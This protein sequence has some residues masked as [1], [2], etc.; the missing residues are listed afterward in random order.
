[1]T[2]SILEISEKYKLGSL[3]KRGH[4]HN[5]T[6]KSLRYSAKSECVVCKLNREAARYQENYQECIEY[7]KEYDKQHY[8]QI[9]VRRSNWLKTEA[10]KKSS[11]QYSEKRSQQIRAVHRSGYSTQELRLHLSQFDGKCVYCGKQLETW[12][13]KDHFIPLSLG[14]SDCLGNLVSCCKSCNSSKQDKDP[15]E[16]YKSKSFYSKAQWDLILRHLG[17]TQETYNI[18]P[19]F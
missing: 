10:G 11:R 8:E 5:G 19:F 4:G 7:Q 15:Y 13:R 14:G 3:C 2:S 17:K 16:W 9:K 12:N 18:I 6:G 1:M